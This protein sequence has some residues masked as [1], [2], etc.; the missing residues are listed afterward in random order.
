LVRANRVRAANLNRLKAANE[1]FE[2]IQNIWR[3]QDTTIDLVLEAQRRVIEAKLQYFQT[4]VE[5]MLAIK[6]IHFEKG[7]LFAYHNVALSES[8]ADQLAQEQHLRRIASTS[9]SISYWIPGLN[10]SSGPA[11][12]HNQLSE[13]PV[14]PASP[15]TPVEIWSPP[16]TGWEHLSQPTIQPVETSFPVITPVV[17]LGLNSDP[18]SP[19][20]Q[21]QNVAGKPKPS[22]A[23]SMSLSDTTLTNVKP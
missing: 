8:Q 18:N 20:N 14:A 1:Q 10:T 21:S 22:T 2:A 9:R 19:Q 13:A 12:V 23:I 16:T 17:P 7:T 11:P 3:E 6:A 5:Y 4:Q 15:L